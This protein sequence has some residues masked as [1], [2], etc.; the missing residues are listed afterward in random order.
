MQ[1]G[2]YA[3]VRHPIYFGFLVAAFG[4]IIVLGEFRALALLFGIEVLLNKMRHEERILSTTF[5]AQYP[6]Y[7]RRVKR[8]LPGIW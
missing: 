7:E 1:D 6:Q 4:M 2:P 3:I 8:L 5:P